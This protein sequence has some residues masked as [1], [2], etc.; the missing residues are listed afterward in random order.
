[1]NNHSRGSKSEHLC[2]WE[3]LMRST[4]Q[5]K[6][7]DG[8]DGHTADGSS[9]HMFCTFYSPCETTGGDRELVREKGD[10]GGPQSFIRWIHW[11]LPCKM[12]LHTLTH[13]HKEQAGLTLSVYQKP[14]TH[15][16]WLLFLAAWKKR[17]LCVY[18]PLVLFFSLVL[19]WGKCAHLCDTSLC[20]L[21]DW[22]IVYPCLLFLKINFKKVIFFLPNVHIIYR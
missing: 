5:E 17:E 7:S 20:S 8:W 16:D 14:T 10:H 2:V 19:L 4:G 11:A 12:R 21:W 13:A 15:R 9:L 6:N 18:F 3:I 1:M 22:H